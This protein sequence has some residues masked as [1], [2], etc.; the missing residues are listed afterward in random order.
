LGVNVQPESVEI[1]ARNEMAIL[2]DDLLI[3]ENM[4]SSTTTRKVAKGVCTAMLASA[5]VT[6]F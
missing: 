6:M 2:I 5:P 4:N 1:N 3:G